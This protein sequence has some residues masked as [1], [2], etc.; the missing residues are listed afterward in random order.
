[1]YVFS[2]T[3]VRSVRVRKL[4]C[5]TS[6]SHPPK[7]FIIILLILLPKCISNVALLAPD[8]QGDE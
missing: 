4:L 7:Q 1:M 3:N 6:L 2:F 5:L 8:F